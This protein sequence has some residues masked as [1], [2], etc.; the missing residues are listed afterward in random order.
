MRSRQS[1]QTHLKRWTDLTGRRDR[2][3]TMRS[4]VR[5]LAAAAINS[6]GV[7]SSM[8]RK[9]PAVRSTAAAAARE[10]SFLDLFSM[11]GAR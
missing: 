11:A 3:S 6:L 8:G 4:S 5:R 2:I 10:L 1:L 9:R 7:S